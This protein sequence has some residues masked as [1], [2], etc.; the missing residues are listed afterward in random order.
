MASGKR[1]LY[2]GNRLAQ[3]GMTVTSI[4]TLGNFLKAEGY[5]MRFASSVKN[6][7]FRMLDMLWTTIRQSGK[8]SIVLI[9]TYST[10]NFHYAVAV[11]NLCRLLRVPYIPILR[12]GN[13]PERLRRSPSQAYKLFH[14]AKQNVAPSAFLMEH[15]KDEGYNNLVY[16]PN[17]IDLDKYPFKLR[18][19]CTAKLL[20]VR[21]FADIYNP[22]LA[23]KL[24]EALI[25]KGIE[26]SLCMVGPDKDGS[27][28]RCKEYA[29][30]HALP[31]VFTGKLDKPDWIAMA[32]E[33]DIFINTTNF[34]NTPVSVIEAMALG[35]PV[36]STDV[37]GIPYLLEHEKD[38]LLVPP[39]D[40]GAFVH[41]V[42]SL[43][44]NPSKG[45]ELAQQA[46][47]KVEN[48]DWA[49]VKHQWASLLNE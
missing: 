48:F 18:E 40:V 8:T 22:M 41:Y 9:D 17:T 37:G 35:L 4:E 23:L 44:Q 7:F 20:W 14:G 3:K 45:R 25:Q 1:I 31:V 21:S 43:L 16:I 33:F 13:L 46:R 11:G 36:I 29:E 15:F 49:V 39:E 24:V 42:E 27:M 30:K 12:G 26:T 2:I 32:A 38:A 6:K 28:I 47:S 5:D 34:D 19:Q 10:Q